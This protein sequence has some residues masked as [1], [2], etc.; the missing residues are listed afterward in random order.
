MC[1]NNWK[2]FKENY[3][4]QKPQ[5]S[6]PEVVWNLFKHYSV[7]QAEVAKVVSSLM[8]LYIQRAASFRD[9]S[10]HFDSSA[11]LLALS[12]HTVCSK[13]VKECLISLSIALRYFIIRLVW[14]P[15]HGGIARICKADEFK[16]EYTLVS[17]TLYWECHFEIRII[18]VIYS[19]NLAK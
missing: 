18:T 1:N 3:F 17:R 14:L 15:G 16:R 19:A 6:K 2:L 5:G 9:V 10:I 12:S 11:A 4:W 8:Y 7:F 13:L